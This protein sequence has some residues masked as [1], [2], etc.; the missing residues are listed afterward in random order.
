MKYLLIFTLYLQLFVSNFDLIIYINVLTGLIYGFNYFCFPIKKTYLY[1]LLILSGTLLLIY[2]LKSIFLS[3]MLP[4]VLL[5]V[6]LFCQLAGLVIGVLL[7]TRILRFIRLHFML[8]IIVILTSGISRKLGSGNSALITIFI[9]TAAS[10]YLFSNSRKWYSA[11]V[12]PL[13]YITINIVFS[14]DG[15][16]LQ[17]IP[18]MLFAIFSGLLIYFYGYKCEHSCYIR[19][20]TV[21]FLIIYFS[22]V[23]LIQENY[24]VWISCKQQNKIGISKHSFDIKSQSIGSFS[25][26]SIKKQ[27]V[28][29]FWSA[30]CGRCPNEFPYM[31]DLAN[32]F[33]NVEVMCLFISLREKDTAYYNSLASKSF[34]FKWGK[35]INGSEVMNKLQIDGFPHITIMSANDSILYNGVVC[36]RPW[37]FINHPRYFISH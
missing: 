2:F 37:L 26:L 10:L 30:N 4:V 17:I 34:D 8:S 14:N 19:I 23:W 21:L 28:F 16:Y 33:K 36:N 22:S 5:L 9:V 6:M 11:F 31:S 13:T 25:T 3:R 15:G 18:V 12:V 20:L 24:Q 32:K 7:N 35:A 27:K 29:L 1:D